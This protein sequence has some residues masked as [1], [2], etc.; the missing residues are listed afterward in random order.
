MS[1]CFNRDLNNQQSDINGDPIDTVNLQD[2]DILQYNGVTGVWENTP[3]SPALSVNLYNTSSSLT[4]N[5]TVT[6]VDKN[7]LFSG[8]NN[9]QLDVNPAAGKIILGADNNIEINNV[10]DMK[11]NVINGVSNAVAGTDAVNLNQ[12][13]VVSQIGTVIFNGTLFGANNV[14]RFSKMGDITYS[15]RLVQLKVEIRNNF[16]FERS[17]QV[18]HFAIYDNQTAGNY[19]NVR[20]TRRVQE[21]TTLGLLVRTTS[22]TTAE[23]WYYLVGNNTSSITPQCKITNFGVS[24]CTFAQ[25]SGFSTG[26]PIAQDLNN[27]LDNLSQQ[28]QTLL[29]NRTIDINGLTLSVLNG[30]IQSNTAPAV[31]DDYCNK[32]YVDGVV[33]APNN[34]YQNDGTVTQPVRNVFIDGSSLR[35]RSAAANDMLELDKVADRITVRSTLNTIDSA[36]LTVNSANVIF[37]SQRIQNVADPTSNQDVATKIYADNLISS[38]PT[39]YSADG[40]LFNNRTVTGNANNLTISGTNVTTL[41]SNGNTII[42]SNSN[43]SVLQ[44]LNNQISLDT[45]GSPGIQ[46]GGVSFATANNNFKLSYPTPVTTETLLVLYPDQS[47]NIPSSPFFMPI[48]ELSFAGL[49]TGPTSFVTWRVNLAANTWTM[50]S[51]NPGPANAPT[52]NVVPAGTFIIGAADQYTVQYKKTTPMKWHCAFSLCIAVQ[53]VSRTY[54]FRTVKN[55]VEVPG[56]LIV[57]DPPSSNRLFATAFHITLDLAFDD[58]V[59]LEVQCDLARYVDVQNFNMVLVGSRMIQ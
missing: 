41:S 22:F 55:G 32:T 14:N 6:M 27:T 29:G 8:D 51:F 18:F 44:L 24:P 2:D 1:F 16:N 7:L 25:N 57:I 54:S 38:K 53:S 36:I 58:I 56:S 26:L 5:R 19:H 46:L 42:N 59:G 9:T 49:Q 52:L 17:S 11:N 45:S 21:D 4:D 50:L 37:N 3:L 13:N 34:I 12:L 40:F 43:T 33:G 15:D 35:F 23:L 47:V 39:L 20:V 30:N 48:G 10:L 28:N 31:G